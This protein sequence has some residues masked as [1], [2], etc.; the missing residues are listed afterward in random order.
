MKSRY[1][2]KRGEVLPMRRAGGGVEMYVRPAVGRRVSRSSAVTLDQVG[3]LISE[4]TI[5][6]DRAGYARLQRWAD[7]LGERRE[8]GIE[9]CGSYRA[10]V[11]SFPR[12]HGHRVV[13]VNRPDRRT[14][15]RGK[16]D[17]IDAGR[18]TR[19]V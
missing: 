12:R 8:F 17:A 18:V 7:E 19:T 1:S 15:L 3:V 5:S 11:T 4:T 9:G 10:G 6:A 16:N 2:G 13:E 14:H